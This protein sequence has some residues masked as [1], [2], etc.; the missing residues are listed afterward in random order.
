MKNPAPYLVLA[1]CSISLAAVGGCG[2]RGLS[3]V[4]AGD[5]GVN[6]DPDG[7]TVPDVPSAGEAEASSTGEA[8]A[9][10]AGQTDLP[11][12]PGPDVGAETLPCTPE[13][14]KP[15]SLGL[16]GGDL[17]GSGIALL[18]DRLFVG[19][20]DRISLDGQ[21]VGVSL[22]TGATTTFPLGSNIPVSL[23]ARQDALFY[24][25]GAVEAN[26]SQ[27]GWA[28][29]YTRVARLDLQ[30][31]QVSLFDNPPDFASPMV[32]LVVGNA[33]GDIFWAVSDGWSPLSVL[34][35][36]D[37]STGAAKTVLPAGQILDV[38]T[39]PST[40]Y[41]RS[42][43]ES[44]HVVLLSMPVGG[45][46]VSVLVEWLDPVAN[47][48]GLLGMDDEQLYYTKYGDIPSGIMAMP[49]GG[50]EGKTIVPNVDP[51]LHA[52]DD[53]HIY[54]VN[55]GEV[56]LYRAPKNGGA[57]ETVWDVPNRWV[58]DLAVDACNM[59]WTVLNP[60]EIYARAK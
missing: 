24:A 15:T 5:S 35:G 57:V 17:H 19:V 51:T 26:S 36:W 37:P 46:P 20:E 56:A 9:S 2:R 29:T 31:G 43:N 4:D 10:G 55:N 22:S 16:L 18:G 11:T 6:Q 54:W 53:T 7:A 48:P 8:D 13:L 23:T 21:I 60:P 30:T 38:W 45:G 58:V 44:N 49:K 34:M 50:G 47:V 25:Q 39:D 59:Y 33:K 12:Q 1:V 40:L 32:G 27:G 41:W 42:V 14:Q 3:K 52:I 28:I